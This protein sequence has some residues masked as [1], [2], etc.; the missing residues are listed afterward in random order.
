MLQTKTIKVLN[1]CCHCIFSPSS[2]D[3]QAP[4]KKKGNE[5][6]KAQGNIIQHCFP[7]WCL[8]L[9]C[10]GPRMPGC[11]TK[12][13]GVSVR[14]FPDGISIRISR[15][16]KAALPY[17]WAS[18][19]SRRVWMEKKKEWR[20]ENRLSAWLSWDRGL[21]HLNWELQMYLGDIPG[22]VPDYPQIL[23]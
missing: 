11:L 7:V 19:K 13:P 6:E 20:K 17:E 23:Q 12:L 18:S 10:L 5:K 4:K 3:P 16:H 21:L 15:L 1:K 14:V 2:A 9:G 8:I 22:S